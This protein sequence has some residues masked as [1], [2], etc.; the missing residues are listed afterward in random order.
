MAILRSTIS[1]LVRWA[2]KENLDP[3]EAVQDYMLEKD[4]RITRA[5]ASDL[6]NQTRQ[7]MKG[8]KVCPTSTKNIA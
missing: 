8:E 4:S 7:A 5:D 6:V 2:D 3:V 1:Q